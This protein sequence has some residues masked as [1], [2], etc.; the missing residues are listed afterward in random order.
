[1]FRRQELILNV[2]D[3]T[4]RERL[5]EEKW[6]I[7]VEFKCKSQFVRQKR[8]QSECVVSVK[9]YIPPAQE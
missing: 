8:F 7:T 1:M 3:V 9:G 4:S 5:R 6:N 2:A